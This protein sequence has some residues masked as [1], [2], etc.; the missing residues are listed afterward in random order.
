MSR[1]DS[2]RRSRRSHSAS[3]AAAGVDREPRAGFA[4]LPWLLA[5]ALLALA[6][7]F[8]IVR[9]SV[10]NA[11]LE[12]SP[13]LAATVAPGDSSLALDRV[14]DALRRG[15]DI[16]EATR[17]TSRHA[18]ER[19]PLASEPLLLAA[20][21]ALD[22]GDQARADRL[23]A[24]AHRRNPRSRYTLMLLLEQHLRHGRAEDLAGVM[25]VLTRL[26]SEAGEVLLSLLARMA[27]EPQ[28]SE[29]VRE[30]IQ[31]DPAIR[32]G[33]LEQLARQGADPDRILELAGG[34]S[35]PGPGEETPRWQR[36]M[37]E[38]LVSRGEVTSAYEAW[39]RLAGAQAASAGAL[40]YDPDFTR[41]PGPPPFN[42]SFE[43]TSHGFAEVS[44]T[45]PGLFAEYY[46]RK[47]VSLGGQLVRLPPGRYNLG[48]KAEGKADGEDG[49]LAWVISCHPSGRPIG[50]VPIT[51]VDYTPKTISGSFTVPASGCPAQWLRLVGKASE[52]PK[53]QQVTIRT[54]RL[55][56][57][58]EQ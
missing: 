48:F 6:L 58:G 32:V 9:I 13:E 37:L 45:S 5:A 33:V 10:V 17:N 42:W 19:A 29:A 22:A 23:I 24:M 11:L 50:E 57:A 34:D 14:S 41:L 55:E 43:Q 56:K 1:S 30:V 8:L 52:F 15:G 31:S 51:G 2:G 44:R 12:V 18:F 16:D 53:E 54:L 40:V 4:G 46:A 36:L 26:Q 49:R 39:T 47:S 35:P 28:T 7:V 20:R 27:T 25:A 21:Q 3:T 38:G